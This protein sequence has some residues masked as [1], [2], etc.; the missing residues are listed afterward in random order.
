MNRGCRLTCRCR[1]KFLG[2]ISR[3]DRL[4]SRHWWKVRRI[5]HR[6]ARKIRMIKS[7]RSVSRTTPTANKWRW[8]STTRSQRTYFVRRPEASCTDRRARWASCSRTKRRSRSSRGMRRTRTWFRVA[9]RIIC[10]LR[11]WGRGSRI[12][13]VLIRYSKIIQIIRISDRE[14]RE[15]LDLLS[16]DWKM[17]TTHSLGPNLSWILGCQNHRTPPPGSWSRRKILAK[18]STKKFS[19]I[20]TICRIDSSRK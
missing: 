14:G 13:T 9:T 17:M 16:K 6:R 7:R 20:N 3:I 18:C 12:L 8:L 4:M 1:I 19:S 5:Q 11:L 10:R 2:K 15:V